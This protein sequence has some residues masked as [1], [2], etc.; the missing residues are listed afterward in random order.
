MATEIPRTIKE[1]VLA[2]FMAWKLSP[3][4]VMAAEIAEPDAVTAIGMTVSGFAA[5]RVQGRRG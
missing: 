2:D 5:V 1:L 3:G 4:F